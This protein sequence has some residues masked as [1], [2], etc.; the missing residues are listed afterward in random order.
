[1]LIL[2]PPSEGKSEPAVGP[3]VVLA[4]LVFDEHLGDYRRRLI[5]KLGNLAKRPVAKAVEALGISPGQAGDIERDAEISTAPAARAAELYSG[6]LY[7]HLDLKSLRG[8][9]AKRPA[10]QLLIASSL[11]GMLRPDDHIPYYRLSMKA[12]LPR[13]A[14]LAA[15]WR[16]PL[17]AAMEA[18]GYDSEGKLILDMRSGAYSTAWKP[19]KACLLPVRAFNEV[20]GKRKAI[21]HMAKARR[22][23]VA[24]L[25]LKARKTPEDAESVADLLES[26]GL[27]VELSDSFLDV[28]ESA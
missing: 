4:E 5:E 14:G 21:S 6:V 10:E 2:L 19:K 12:K 27:R 24:Q 15:Y 17:A 1:M 11:W 28:I 3:P 26:A 20:D 13:I 22:G 8:A 18:G 9:A 25:V 7:D 23:D 16:A